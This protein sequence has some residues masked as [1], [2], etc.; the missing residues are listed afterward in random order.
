MADFFVCKPQPK[1]ALYVFMS[2]AENGVKSTTNTNSDLFRKLPLLAKPS[3]KNPVTVKP[4]T[5][6]PITENPTQINTKE[7]NMKESNTN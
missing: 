1:S 6:E 2:H 3:S 5:D 4:A 7:V